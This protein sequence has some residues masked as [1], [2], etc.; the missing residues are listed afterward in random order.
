L[1]GEADPARDAVALNAAAAIAVARE[2]FGTD[3]LRAA[4]VEAL[5]AIRSGAAHRTLE[6]WR[7][8]AREAMEP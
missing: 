1:R 2:A 8:A 6:A 5:E 7:T 4:G 3:A